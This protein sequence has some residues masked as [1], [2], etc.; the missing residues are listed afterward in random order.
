MDI[1]PTSYPVCLHRAHLTPDDLH[2][3]PRLQ[4]D[5]SLNLK[6]EHKVIAMLILK[7]LVVALLGLG[8]SAAPAERERSP[9]FLKL[10]LD[11]RDFVNDTT[12]NELVPRQSITSSQTGTNNGYYYSFLTD[13][14]A[15]VTYTNGA[16]GSYSTTWGSGVGE[17]PRPYISWARR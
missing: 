5:L 12:S 11:D 15:S 8:A 17:S 16:G 3:H 7:G 14:G 4:S 9:D 1:K 6:L 13:G 2:E 10:L